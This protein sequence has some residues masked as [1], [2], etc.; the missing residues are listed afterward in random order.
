[1]YQDSINAQ[2]NP[3]QCSAAEKYAFAYKLNVKQFID[4]VSQTNGI[5][6]QQSRP[7]CTANSQCTSLNDG[8]VCAKRTGETRGYCIPGWYG[9]CHAWAPAA[10]LEP[11]PKCPV[12][13]NNVAFQ[14]F[15]IKALLTAIYDGAN[16]KTVF[17]G[18]HF[19]GP[20]NA[21]N[22]KDKYGRF[23]NL[24]E[25]DI[26]A[27]FFHLAVA[28]ILGRF[29]QSFVVDVTADSEVWN[30]PVCGYEIL[31]SSTMTPAQAA[32]KYFRTS[33]YPFNNAARKIMYVKN[34]FSWV[35]EM[36]QDGALVSLGQ[37]AK[38]V[39]FADYTCLLE[40]DAQSNVIGGEWV[41]ASM[42]EHPDFLWLPFTKP[43]AD[44]VTALGLSYK[45]VQELLT[46]SVN[47][48]C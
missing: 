17:T 44:A 6:S 38:A 33:T 31:E 46:A 47:G 43:A 20:D 24:G 9:I 15:D 5:L 21:S 27:G 28:N 3:G 8:S 2:W 26:G 45:N 25:R 14:A 16:I 34:R 48:R 4:R 13:K 32:Q 1:M 10:I 37:A 12:T 7:A 19:N 40:L 35:V 36:V 11:E 29:K 18:V 22:N 30:Q 41:G 23:T 39:T 42:A